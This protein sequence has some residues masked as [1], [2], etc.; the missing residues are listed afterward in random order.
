M[1]VRYPRCRIFTDALHA[2]QECG[3][4]AI[5]P[6]TGDFHLSEREH[7]PSRRSDPKESPRGESTRTSIRVRVPLSVSCRTDRCQVEGR[8]GRWNSLLPEFGSRWRVAGVRRR[9]RVRHRGEGV[10]DGCGARAKQGESS[11]S[12]SA[13]AE[14]FPRSRCRRRNAR[15]RRAHGEPRRSVAGQPAVAPSRAGRGGRTALEALGLWAGSDRRL[16]A[17]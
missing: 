4:A 3:S 16:N 9:R 5:A 10:D 7:R 12:L 6:S 14:R 2:S 1:N 17:S 15:P 8:A 11:D 13:G